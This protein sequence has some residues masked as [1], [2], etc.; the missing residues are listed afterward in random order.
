[1]S[2]NHAFSFNG[3]HVGDPRYAVQVTRSP[4]TRA[5]GLVDDL[6]ESARGVALMGKRR[7]TPR[8]IRLAC[9]LYASS[10][11]DMRAKFTALNLAL[12]GDDAEHRLILD[13][14]PGVFYNA[15]LAAGINDDW[16]RF[17]SAFELPFICADPF[18]YATSQ[19]DQSETI[20]SDPDTLTFPSGSGAITGAT[21]AAP[22]VITSVGHGRSTG[23]TLVLIGVG[24]NTAANG[25]WVI[26]VT[27]PDTF[28]LDG[29]EGNGAY[30]SGGT[31][32]AAAAGTA[33]AEPEWYI[34]NTTG[35]QVSGEIKVENLTLPGDTLTVTVTLD[36]GEWLKLGSRDTQDRFRST[37]DISTAGGSDPLA[38]SYADALSSWKSG[39]M[40]RLLPG[41]QN[42]IK[43]TGLSSGTLRAIY[44]ATYL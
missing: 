2:R 5:T 19:T 42:D 26:T 13:D 28:S 14:F 31:W 10:P 3:I 16:R 7:R 41:V 9:S 8:R 21:N 23:E 18:G 11:D 25:T 40:P 39:L 36:D 15:R 32:E 44:R 27:G 30:T 4:F 17:K 1:M 33:K 35:G 43:V 29:S 24:G 37:I 6:Q 22:I 38:L 12:A 20:G 34:R